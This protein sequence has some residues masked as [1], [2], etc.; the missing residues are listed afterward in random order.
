MYKVVVIDDEYFLRKSM[1]ETFNWNK[2]G[3]EICGEAEN[4]FDGYNLIKKVI[5]H[6]AFIDISMPVLSGLELVEK[7]RLENNDIE[8]VIMSGYS[9]FEY[10]KKCL[11]LNVNNYLVKPLN[12]IDIKNELLKIKDKLNVHFDDIEFLNNANIIVKKIKDYIKNNLDNSDLKI[13]SISQNLGYSYHYICKI[14]LEQTN[15]NLGKYILKKRMEKAK[16]LIENGEIN[17]KD[18][19]KKSG[20]ADIFYFSKSFKKYYKLTPTQF[21]KKNQSKN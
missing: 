2:L 18:I 16:S 12:D 8:I 13:D 15:F 6:L 5:P 17:I 3:F 14:F 19:G 20:Y 21:I 4:G 10:A 1:I 7:L 9:E 11:P